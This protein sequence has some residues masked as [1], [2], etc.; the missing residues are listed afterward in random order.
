MAHTK[1]TAPELLSPSLFARVSLLKARFEEA[2]LSATDAAVGAS[3]KPRTAT[4]ELVVDGIGEL[5]AYVTGPGVPKS[6]PGFEA[7]RSAQLAA[8]RLQVRACVRVC[9]RAR[10]RVGTAGS[11]VCRLQTRVRVQQWQHVAATA[12]GAASSQGSAAWQAL[13]VA[14]GELRGVLG[15][16]A[17]PGA[18]Q[19][20][21]CR[22]QRTLASSRPLYA[23]CRRCTRLPWR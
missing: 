12:Q 10:A 9:E 7:A 22:R 18:A 8:L 2:S 4:F 17:V 5:L 16:H 23:P 1:V 3:R 6:G 11:R 13:D 14:V 15:S 20:K 19:D 21:V